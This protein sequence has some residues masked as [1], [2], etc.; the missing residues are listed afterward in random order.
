MMQTPLMFGALSDAQRLALQVES[1][2]ARLQGCG[3]MT[4]RQ[5]CARYDYTDRELRRLAEHSNGDIISGQQ[6]YRLTHEATIDEV[7][8]AEAW[9]L[10]QAAKMRERALEIRL[11]RNR[12]PVA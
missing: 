5:L 1:L 6:G 7:N 11:A 8:H 10:S 3:W 9:L 4:R 12:R 2:K